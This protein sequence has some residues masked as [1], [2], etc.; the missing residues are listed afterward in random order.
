MSDLPSPGDDALAGD[1]GLRRADRA[2]RHQSPRQTSELGRAFG[3]TALGTVLPGAGLALG[4]WG[5][6]AGRVLVGVALVSGMVLIGYVVQHG[7][8]RS[9][10]DLAAR[11]NQLRMLAVALG[12]GGL[13]WML[14]IALT[15]VHNHPDR[16]T[17]QQRLGLTGFT[18]VMCL[19]VATPTAVGL[20]YI[21][22]HNTAVDKMFTGPAPREEGEAAGAVGLPR[23]PNVE[24]EDPW[25]G[26]GRVNLLLLGSDAGHNREG[27]RTDS[28]I[29]AS[30]DT[31]TGDTVLFG[32]PRNLQNVPIPQTSPLHRVWPEGYNCGNPCLMNGIWTEAEVLAEEHPEWFAGDPSPGKT[33]TREVISAI[34][35][36][37]IHHTLLVDL[38]GFEELVDAMGGVD[39]DV[40]ERVPIGGKTYT[41]EQGRS[42]LIEGS[43]DGWIEVGPQRL[44]GREAL[45]YARSRVTTDDFS[46]MRRQRCVVAAVV[47]Q[48]DPFTMLQRYPQI[49]SAAG[50]NI[51]VDIP[52]EDLPAWAEL[53]QRVQD[54]QIKSLPFT[55]QNIDV[56]DP[57]YASIRLLVYRAL[58]PP[59]PATPSSPADGSGPQTGPEPTSPS[60]TK[61][62]PTIGEPSTTDSS[63]PSETTEP[64]DELADVGA[65]C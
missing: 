52:Q 48:V 49:I 2:G 23:R 35:G 53:V 58:H 26:M 50:D 20:R 36:E 15:A 7:A 62:A 5:R 24:E 14:S 17:S 54:G 27:V 12:L 63:E 40:Q 32:I 33:A 19:V 21:E 60:T 47:Q 64:T 31:A 25:A 29:V 61:P 28:M 65:V 41:D 51:S 56:T 18:A 4:R 1:D 37:P 44:S 57:A 38:R 59:P 10:L 46:R 30:I 43:V 13:V 9:A 11:P 6:N 34:L 8:L 16:M 55:T 39:I 22:V 42:W 45:W 3:L